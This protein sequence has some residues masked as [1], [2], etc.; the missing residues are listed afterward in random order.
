MATR[1]DVAR[2]AGTS[3]SVVSYVVD[4]GPRSVAPATGERVLAAVRALDYRPNGVARSL[5][6]A[7]R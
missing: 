4:N 6:R 1:Q 3:P 2:L 7:G 5:R